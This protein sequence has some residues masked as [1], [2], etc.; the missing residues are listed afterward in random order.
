VTSFRQHLPAFCTFTCTHHTYVGVQGTAA[1]PLQPQ[2]TPPRYIVELLTE[3]VAPPSRGPRS[4]W[5]ARDL[6]PPAPACHTHSTPLPVTT[7]VVQ[8]TGAAKPPGS[9]PPPPPPPDDTE[10]TEAGKNKRKANAASEQLSKEAEVS[11]K[12]D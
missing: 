6:V 3:K 4:K 8:T 2:G 9:A 11:K 7:Q 5:T 1:S 10:M 12:K